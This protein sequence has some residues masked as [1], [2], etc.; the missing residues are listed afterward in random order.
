MTEWK[1]TAISTPPMLNTR[2]PII[3]KAIKFISGEIN[4]VP[5][6]PK[7]EEKTIRYGPSGGRCVVHPF[8][9]LPPVF[10]F[11]SSLFCVSLS[12]RSRRIASRIEDSCPEFGAIG[13]ELKQR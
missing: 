3:I 2:E 4:K 8:N 11:L 7:K 1:L 9:P 13:V 6:Q 10:L 12:T 5:V